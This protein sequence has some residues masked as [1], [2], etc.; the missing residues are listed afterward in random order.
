MFMQSLRDGAE[1]AGMMDLLVAA[2]HDGDIEFLEE[3]LLSDM[4]RYP[5]LNKIIVVDRNRSW[6]KRIEDLL[7]HENNYLIVVGTLHLVGEEGVPDL[8]ENRGYKVTQLRQ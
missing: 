8:L 6:A 7:T 4:Q 5:E 2:W 3:N 1:V